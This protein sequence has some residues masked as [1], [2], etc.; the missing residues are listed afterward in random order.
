[1]TALSVENVWKFYGD[2]PALRDIR[3][4]A[5][6]GACVALLGRNGA[7]KTTLLRILAGLSRPTR[8]RVRVFG[9]DCLDAEVRRRTGLIGHGIGIYDELSAFENLRLFAALYGAGD[10][11]RTALEWLERTGLERVRDALVR[12]FSRGMRQRL[13]VARAFLHRPSLL[14]LD[15][16]FTALDDRAIALLQGLLK[17][18]LA[19]GATVVMSTHQLR[20]ALE[21]ATHVVLIVRGRLAHTGPRTREMLDDPGWLYRTYGEA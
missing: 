10:P 20:E 11:R 21:L 18:S 9:T 6:Q 14:L 19:Q 1:M 17:E 5:P 16:P 7:G 8:G 2:F 4:E 3:F 13:A 15:E 12:E